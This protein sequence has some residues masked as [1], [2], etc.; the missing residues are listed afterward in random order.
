M[1]IF[2]QY[3]E[4]HTFVK[5]IQGHKSQITFCPHNTRIAVLIN[6]SNKSNILHDKKFS[7][8]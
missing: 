7:T 3:R 6:D 1:H 8:E 2:N 4:D 5:S